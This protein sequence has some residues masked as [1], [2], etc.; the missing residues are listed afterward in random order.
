MPGIFRGLKY[1]INSR[2]RLLYRRRYPI[3]LRGHPQLKGDFFTRSLGVR[4]DASDQEQ[5]SAWQQIHEDYECFIEGLTAINEDLIED[6]DI[7]RRARATLRVHGLKPGLLSPRP[8]LSPEANQV[9]LDAAR[10]QL[11]LP[12]SPDHSVVTTIT[13]PDDL[14]DGVSSAAFRLLTQPTQREKHPMRLL[15]DCWKPYCEFKEIDVTTR[16][17]RRDLRRWERFLEVSGDHMLDQQAV[18]QALDKYVETRSGE[19]SGPSVKRELQGVI[20]IIRHVIRLKRLPI[21][22]SPPPIKDASKHKRRITLT[23]AECQAVHNHIRRS[24][25][26][27]EYA[28]VVYLMFHGLIASEI[29]RLT[30]EALRL[31]AAIP[32]VSIEGRTKTESRKRYVPIALGLNELRTVTQK[33]S[34]HR[35]GLG[36]LMTRTES[37][38]SHSLGKIVRQGTGNARATPYSLRHTLKANL[39][40][41]GVDHQ[42]IALIGGWSGLVSS[43]ML[44][45]GSDAYAESRTLAQLQ[46]ALNRTFGQSGLT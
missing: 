15:S 37:N 28:C 25:V 14:W 27:P 4:S 43:V 31:D 22:I 38:L 13:P 46:T 1:T 39:L 36:R 10:H 24:S 6:A 23:H 21:V 40:A 20:A 8:R 45:Y 34:H 30:P 2:G 17:G 19:V 41:C 16:A 11:S 5:L 33:Y 26:R 42:L 7:V 3:R 32:Y 44:G 9:I 29:A 12:H 18:H 35:H